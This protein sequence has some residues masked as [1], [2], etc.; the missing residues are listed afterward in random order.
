MPIVQTLSAQTLQLGLFPLTAHL[1]PGGRMQ[2]RVFEPRYVRLVRDAL[3]NDQGFGLC[4]L[5]SAGDTSLNQHIF[6][7]GTRAKII[8]FETLADGY[9]GITI[10]GEQLFTVDNIVTEKDGLRVGSV[11]LIQPLAPPPELP[12]PDGCELQRRLQEVF[13]KYPE[14]AKLYPEQYFQDPLWVCYRWL[15]IL[16]L[17]AATKQEILAAPELSTMQQY[18][19]QLF[20]ENQAFEN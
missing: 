5:N 16:P 4:M 3:R 17:S 2:L 13:S 7:I 11:E 10:A 15:E 9:L 8:D 19:E 6:P 1:L 20:V 14:F 18:L 12:F